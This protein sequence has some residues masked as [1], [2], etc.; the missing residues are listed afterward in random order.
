MAD[1]MNK[2]VRPID[3]SAKTSGNDFNELLLPDDAAT[4]IETTIPSTPTTSMNGRSIQS[5]NQHI[6][7]VN[8]SASNVEILPSNSNNASTTSGNN[9]GKTPSD[10]NNKTVQEP[11]PSLET[12]PSTINEIIST[13]LNTIIS[14]CQELF[15]MSDNDLQTLTKN[16]LIQRITRLRQ[17]H[18]SDT[19]SLREPGNNRAQEQDK[20][21][22]I[23]ARKS[24]FF[25]HWN[26]RSCRQQW[27]KELIVKQ[28]Y[29]HRIQ[30]AA[31]SETSIY[32]SGVTKID[33]YTFIYSGASSLT[34]TRSAHGVALCFGKQASKSWRDG[35]STWE[36]VSDRILT[37]RLQR[38]PIYITIIAVYSPI[39]P[40]PGQSTAIDAADAFYIDLQQT[41]DKTP[42]NE[43]VLIMGD[44]NARV[45]QQQH[46]D[47]FSVVGK[48]AVDDL[49]ENGQRL[50]DFC[51]NNDIIIANTF[52]EHKPI[53][54]MTWM[55]PGNKKWHMIDYTL[56]NRKFRSSVED[57]RVYRTAASVIGTDHHLVRT[58]LKFHLKS[59]VKTTQKQFSGRLNTMKLRDPV[60]IQTFQAALSST[61][62]YTSPT[63]AAND[64]YVELS[65]TLKNISENIF[66]D[67]GPPRKHKEWLTNEILD[68]VGKKSEAFLS[69]Q[70][71]RGTRNEK[72]YRTQ[73]NI[74]RKLAKK[75]VGERQVE[76]W[77]AL[78]LE[79]E[80][81]IKQHDPATAYRMI[82][83]LKGGKAKI[84]EMPIYD[85]QGI[86]LVN[87]YDRLHRW[88]EYFSE[89]FNVPTT[90]DPATIQ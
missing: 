8:Y 5:S 73:Y 13:H 62:T 32:D 67:T 12:N 4:S 1:D 7:S 72:K 26:V 58:K 87:S 45:S 24:T 83:R 33:D 49:N 37:A 54:Q 42:K 77:D 27:K 29:K 39:N 38:H 31:L 52:F 89:L 16:E 22:C 59:R 60:C 85:K 68:I 3:L 2:S 17:Q 10:R 35:G 40:P 81:A 82:R 51:S 23:G 55:H 90:A 57:V 21:P 19:T 69:W 25:G 43:M 11:S 9:A 20:N 28:L 15:A 88:R 74:L 53:H 14:D 63:I 50:T 36:A 79:I 66:G 61:T 48:H 78:S 86:L 30:V 84:E 65:T 46:L 47:G 64:K 71:H 6:Y 75:K 70:N 76:Y 56:V 44:F 41:L 18:F 80:Q 34:K